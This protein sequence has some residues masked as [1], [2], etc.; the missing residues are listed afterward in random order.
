MNNNTESQPTTSAYITSKELNLLKT[1]LDSYEKINLLESG[2]TTKH[3]LFIALDVNIRK[4]V[5]PLENYDPLNMACNHY[6]NYF[7]PHPNDCGS[8]YICVPSV[9]SWSVDRML[10]WTCLPKGN[11]QLST[12]VEFSTVFFN[13]QLFSN[14]PMSD[15]CSVCYA[16]KNT[17]T[18][19]PTDPS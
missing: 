12:E 15:V 14:P 1:E 4:P 13:E 18:G 6:G 7:L 16:L 19:P 2:T 10:R 17:I 5:N 3:I 8:Y 9:R 11:V